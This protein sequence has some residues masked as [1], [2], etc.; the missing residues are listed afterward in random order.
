[1]NVRQR[2]EPDKCR[3]EARNLLTSV[4]TLIDKAVRTP[5]SKER[6]E[7]YLQAMGMSQQAYTL[8]KKAKA[9]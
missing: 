3:Q 2:C 9:N 5:D 8:L 1:M 6:H 4:S 7:L